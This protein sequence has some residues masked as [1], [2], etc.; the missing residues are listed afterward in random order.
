MAT[1]KLNYAGRFVFQSGLLILRVF[2][3][4][5]GAVGPA[6]VGLVQA[7]LRADERKNNQHESD[8]I[9]ELTDRYEGPGTYRE[10]GPIF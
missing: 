1:G 5:L 2:S 4:L 6:L 10:E 7:S 3:I 9:E 8:F